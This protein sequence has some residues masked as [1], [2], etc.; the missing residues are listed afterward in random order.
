MKWELSNELKSLDE[1]IDSRLKGL[2]TK[3]NYSLTAL[4]NGK[5]VSLSY[6][7][8]MLDKGIPITAIGDY[9]VD[10]IA[11]IAELILI[12]Q[13]K[14]WNLKYR[15]P[16]RFSEGYG[17]STKI[18]DEIKEGI[19]LTVDNG[20]AAHEAIEKAKKKGLYVIV[21]DHHLTVKNSDGTD[22]LPDADIILNP[23]IKNTCDFE[24]YCG[25]GIVYK[26]AEYL[27]P[28]D[29]E[30]LNQLSGY[31]AI[32][33]IADCVPLIEDN[34]K[35][36]KMGLDNLVKSQ[37]T[38][39]L[40]ALMAMSE[41]YFR[42]LLVTKQNGFTERK[43]PERCSYVIIKLKNGEYV[44][45]YYA[46]FDKFLNIN[47]K[48]VPDTDIET[49][50]YEPKGLSSNYYVDESSVAF[51]LAPMLNAPGRLFDDG[52][53]ISLDL[54]TFNGPM[55]E[56]ILK[57]I[58]VYKS[59][60]ERKILVDD[61]MKELENII[62]N[63][64]LQNNYPLCI[65]KPDLHEGIIGI[66]A[67]KILEKYKIPTIVFTDCNGQLKGSARSN[68]H[69]N[70]KELLDKHSNLI[71]KYGGHPEAAGLSIRTM[72]FDEFDRALR[73]SV[74][75]PSGG[76]V[77]YYDLII[78]ED[79]IPE[80]M[81][82]LNVLKPFGEGNSKPICLIRKYSLIPDIYRGE[83]YRICQ[84][85]R[86]VILNGTNSSAIG[87]EMFAKYKNIIN[88]PILNENVLNIVGTLAENH[89]NG[90]VT[91]Q[92]EIIDFKA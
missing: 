23:H 68:E 7:I 73:N 85:G 15:L 26:L 12:A 25:A 43:A 90:K 14:G 39:G 60:E 74:S 92:V 67:G 17:L 88:N 19:V 57:A 37:K 72:D 56:A 49:W 51:K 63:N 52:A 83:T 21:T 46:Q 54:I 71:I 78:E 84:E 38:T 47:R 33:T 3:E 29:T 16:K 44:T 91:P 30:F 5:R 53:N 31:A 24:D 9:D 22:K 75:R 4:H 32:A 65:Y 2:E 20:I 77:L 13:K 8:Q 1:L 10:G 76:D 66:L 45:G 18:V 36:V 82:K 59:N 62:K 81:A 50:A 48:V 58:N 87:F 34:R 41:A 42:P 86:S 6:I 27:F 35:I 40:T 89:F 70:I 64:N 55:K 28:N 11:S 79:E 69:I 80:T 61:G